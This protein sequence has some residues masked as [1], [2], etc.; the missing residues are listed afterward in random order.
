MSER[1]R[2]FWFSFLLYWVTLA[3]CAA[4]ILLVF[5][6]PLLDNKQEQPQGWRLWMAV[7]ARDL[8]LRRTAVASALC[9]AVTAWVFFRPPRKRR[10]LG[11]GDKVPK[12]P[13]PANMAGA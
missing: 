7:F 5:V 10:P 2:R 8:V 3:V 4:L 6:S 9:L 12:P 1:F 13:P 11:K